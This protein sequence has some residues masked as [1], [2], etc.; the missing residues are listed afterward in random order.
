MHRQRCELSGQI[1]WRFDSARIDQRD[2]DA[3]GCAAVAP[4]GLGQIGPLQRDQDRIG[5]AAF[6][7]SKS[8]RRKSEHA[9]SGDIGMAIEDREVF[10]SHMHAQSVLRKPSQNGDLVGAARRAI[11]ATA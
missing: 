10:L 5:R 7:Q 3:L 2:L 1:R 6:N 9:L 8:G 4:A 11:M